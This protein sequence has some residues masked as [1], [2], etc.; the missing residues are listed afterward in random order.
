MKFPANRTLQNEIG[1]RPL[2]KCSFPRVISFAMTGLAALIMSELRNKYSIP[3]CRNSLLIFSP[4]ILIKALIL[5]T[6]FY[7]YQYLFSDQTKQKIVSLD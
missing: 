2:T 7:L 3:L 6:Q 4:Y 5:Y 1:L